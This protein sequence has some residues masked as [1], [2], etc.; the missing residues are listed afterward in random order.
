M[1]SICPQ[2][3]LTN[4]ENFDVMDVEEPSLF[5]Q[6]NGFFFLLNANQKRY[7]MRK[8]LYVLLL[9]V[10]GIIAF[11]TPNRV[12]HAHHQ[13][14]SVAVDPQ[15][16]RTRYDIEIDLPP[17]GSGETYLPSCIRPPEVMP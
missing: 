11:A 17:A 1:L 4:T 15:T 5:H 16:M 12:D 2:H 6:I 9:C 13:E 10:L 14:V 7:T 8:F 3:P